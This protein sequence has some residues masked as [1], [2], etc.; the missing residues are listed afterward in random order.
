MAKKGVPQDEI[1][2][3]ADALLAA[4]ERP[5][6]D[7]VRVAVGR[8]SPNAIG[9]VLDRWWAQLAERM[10]R[11]LALPGLP[12]PVAAAFAQAWEA[13]LAAGRAHAESAI[14]PERAALADVLAKVEAR[15]A[16]E[17]ALAAAA[18]STRQQ[19]DAR[20]QASEA[21]L[22]ISDRRAADLECQLASQATALQAVTLRR[23]ALE[24]RL[25]DA[26]MQGQAAQTAAAAE[27]D[28]LQAHLRQ[29]EDRA[30]SE[31]DRVRQELKVLKAQHTT[32]AREHAAALRASEQGRRSVETLL[33]KTQRELATLAAKRAARPAATAK[34]R[35][36]ATAP[37]RRRTT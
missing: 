19:A 9:P 18:D 20:A 8:G 33:V 4:G 35:M 23:D 12:D 5:T 17:R 29:V 16:A 3:A 25:G 6:A 21:A 32:Q 26:L 15:V 11:R 1:F 28:A 13:A 22:A 36:A 37:S 14:A 30:Y 24:E 10:V 31:V 27:R 34:T 2:Q 7:K